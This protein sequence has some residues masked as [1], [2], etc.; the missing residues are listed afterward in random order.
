MFSSSQNMFHFLFRLLNS[1]LNL[2]VKTI[3]SRKHL[4]D[5]LSFEY[6]LR[7]SH[8]GKDVQYLFLD[9]LQ[10]NIVFYVRFV[11]FL[12]F[13]AFLWELYRNE[14]VRQFLL[15]LLKRN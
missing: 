1:H 8:F 12:Q 2:L 10:F 3:G 4:Q 5:L 6:F 11:Q 9:S 13:F 7:V 14:Q 15:K